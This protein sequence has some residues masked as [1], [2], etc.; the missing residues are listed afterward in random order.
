LCGIGE[1]GEIFIRTPYRSLGYYYAEAET[2]E[3]FV[4]NPFTEDEADVLYITGDRGMYLPDGT[5]QML[6]RLDEQTKIRGVRVEPAEVAAALATLGP[7]A[8]AHVAVAKDAEGET[9]L[10]AY[11]VPKCE[12]HTDAGELRVLLEQRLP[13]AMV[14][15]AYVFLDELPRLPT[16]KIDKSRLP[17]PGPPRDVGAYEPPHTETERQ[18]A[19][20]WSELLHVGNVG[21]RD[22]FFALGGHSLL[23]TRLINKVETGLGMRLPLVSV[24]E[25]P[26]LARMALHLDLRRVVGVNDGEKLVADMEVDEL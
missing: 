15:V 4:R 20:I 12:P 14:P 2:R 11:V 18:L 9:M 7:V 1:R 21:R 16:G 8:D 5:V 19:G 17:L 22:D 25:N 3:R 26:T 6:G 13:A 23:A 10:V 24:F